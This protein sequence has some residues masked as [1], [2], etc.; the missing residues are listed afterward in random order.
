MAAIDRTEGERRLTAHLAGWLGEWPPLGGPGSVTIVGSRHRLAPGWDGTARR[1]VGVDTP[2][3]AVL[4]VPPAAVEVV[5]AM[6]SHLDDLAAQL[7]EALAVPG[8]RF[9][10][11]TFRW[12]CAPADGPDD[13]VWWPTNHPRLPAWLRPFNGEVLVGLVDG[14]VAAGVG[15]KQHDGY[16]HELA[17]VTE[18]AHQG[19]GWARRLVAQAARRVIDDGAIPTY[20]HAPNNTASARTADACGFADEGWKILGLFGGQ[21]A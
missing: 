16:G 20:F 8:S 7:P 15:R 3:G 19:Q 11:G 17:V 5:R 1:A 2:D 9:H 4:S 12:T 21:P 14:I 13:G 10:A 6:G 18:P